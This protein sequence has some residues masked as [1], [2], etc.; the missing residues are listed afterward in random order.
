[1][2]TRLSKIFGVKILPV[3]GKVTSTAKEMLDTEMEYIEYLRNRKKFF[4]MTQVQQTR[5]LV[6]GRSKK[7]EEKKD[8]KR[9][10]GS[11]LNTL[12]KARKIKKALGNKKL[13][14]KTK[15]GRFRRNLRAGC[16]RLNRKFQRSP[17]GKAKKFVSGVG[18]KIGTNVKNVKK[19]AL[20]KV[21]AAPKALKK[22]ISN[23]IPKSSKKKVAQKLV[24]TAT[25]KGL[26]KAGA[27]V[28]AKLAAKTAVKIGLKKIPVVG[29]I[30]GLGF[31]MQRL[32]QGD[33]QGALM[34]AGSG[35]AS[36]IPGPGTAI[37]AG[38]DAALIAKDVTGMK[39][40][41]EVSSPTQA[42]IAEGGEPE[43]VIPHSKLG[44][45][46]QSLLKQV[47]TTLTD[48]T[49]GF[50]Q[51]L[52][53]P[54]AASSAVLGESAKLAAVF[55]GMSMPMSVF[56]GSK[57]K[58]AAMGF[59]KKMGGGALNLAKG[60]FK[61]TPVGMAMSMLNRP[62]KADGKKETFRKRNVINKISEVN[63]VMT[64]SS[65][66]SDTA[67]S[68]GNFPIT[69]TF[70]STEGR[71]RPHGGVDIGTPVGTPVGFTEPGKIL[72]AGKFGGYGNMMDVWL[73]QTK[74]QMRIAH[75]SKFIKRTGEFIAG[76]KLA[77]TGGALGDPGAGN[78]TGPHLHFEA[79]NKKNSTRYGGAG[80]PMPYAPLLSFTAVEPPSGEGGKGGVSYGHPLS[81]TVKW[82]TS[83]G[84]MG[85]PSLLSN[86][87][88]MVGSF[89]GGKKEIQFVPY[90]M[91]IVK[92][93]PVPVRQIVT[94]VEKDVKAY[95]ID[96]FSGKYGVLNG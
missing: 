38:I 68:Y 61:M 34:E 71:T 39:D 48:V 55:G 54:T 17:F 18:E 53:V 44:P 29:L 73:P 11:I 88:S 83:G 12:N 79:D 85:G 15:L 57:I 30:A 67:T 19:A 80:N 2:N 8:K 66:D 87:G 26:K 89:F 70:G 95:G 24:K 84:S 72:A 90:P 23:L 31:G 16:L 42:L 82:P 62:A 28:G 75:L 96:P 81:Q 22:N 25:K 7:E 43:L 58:S 64:S 13:N 92:P 41:G 21:V 9:R 74:I 93:F 5:V 46:F 27:K 65:W 3:A 91:P 50:L 14:K 32:L 94:V 51:T 35:I 49:T 78:S 33:V 56:K 86:I 1:M 45:V 10:S 4:F 59:L 60:A 37:S 76:E 77:E 40:G 63:G 6:R 52:P 20:D 69:D 36:T 47:G